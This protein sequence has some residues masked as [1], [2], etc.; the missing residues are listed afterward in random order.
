[1]EIGFRARGTLVAL[2]ALG[3]AGMAVSAFA[4]SDAMAFACFA[5]AV[6]VAAALLAS[7]GVNTGPPDVLAVPQAAGAQILPG[8]VRDVF[9]CLADP[10]IVLGTSGHVIFANRALKTL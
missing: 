5:V 10:V 1:M 9:E 7:R 3:I 2:A 8:V 6:L 4:G